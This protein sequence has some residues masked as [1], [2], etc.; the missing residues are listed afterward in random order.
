MEKKTT[1]W[2]LQLT[3]KEKENLVKVQEARKVVRN[4]L[5]EQGFLE[6]DIP[7]IF[8]SKSFLYGGVP[9]SGQILNGYLCAVMT[10]FIRRWLAFGKE[11]NLS[12]VY[13]IGKCF[14]DE[15]VDQDHYPVFENL[16]IGVL[17]EDYRF[18]MKL[19]EEMVSAILKTIGQKNI[20]KWRQIPYFQL[21]PKTDFSS[22][23]INDEEALK[24][25]SELTATLIE[26]TFVTELP[27][28]LFG[29]AR[30]ITQYTKERAELFINGIEI[31]NIS[32]FLTNAEELSQWYQEQ[33]IDFNQYLLEREHLDSV[34]T[35]NNETVATGAIGLSRLY[36]VLLGL[37]TIKETV[38]FPYFGGD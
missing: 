5:E 3:L 22:L 14:R 9:I 13:F 23:K 6:V 27:I 12:R 16:A 8:S 34:S 30:K 36:M 10:P 29:P 15:R 25:Y 28:L 18:L 26:P 35:L 38:A 2:E 19:I 1:I 37:R 4:F 7:V 32:T 17:G 31:G 33:D 24:E 20:G 11:L 21:S